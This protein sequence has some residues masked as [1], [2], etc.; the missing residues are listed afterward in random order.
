MEPLSPKLR[1]FYFAVAI[2]I[3]VIVF[4]TIIFYAAGYRFNEAFR[5]VKT[6]GIYIG[7]DIS[8]AEIYVDN[9]LVRHTNVIRRGYFLQNLLPGEHFI[10][11]AKQGYYSWAKR[12]N[13]HAENVVK[14]DAFLIPQMPRL[15]R[16]PESLTLTE[17]ATTTVSNPEYTSLLSMFSEK[18]AVLARVGTTP[19]QELVIS[20]GHMVVL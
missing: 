14:A 13:V 15:R 4:P 12:L 19:D 8:G 1:Y 2:L 5:L 3:F 20:E 7:S 17:K 16:I 6:G 18:Q 11:V 9:K 10:I